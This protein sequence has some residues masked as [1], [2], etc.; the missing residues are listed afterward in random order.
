MQTF[1]SIIKL[2]AITYNQTN[3]KAKASNPLIM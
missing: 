3:I 1:S 2:Q